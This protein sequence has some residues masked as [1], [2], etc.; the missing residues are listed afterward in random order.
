MKGAMSTAIF[1][2]FLMASS[3]SLAQTTIASTDRPPDGDYR[4]I[5]RQNG[6]EVGRSQIHILTHN[7]DVTVTEILV[8]GEIRV[9]S[10]AAYALSPLRLK[11][12]FAE[13]DTGGK[14]Q[15]VNGDVANGVV[16]LHSGSSELAKSAPNGTSVLVIADEFVASQILLPALLAQNSTTH[17]AAVSLEGG[18][19]LQGDSR[20]ASDGPDLAINLGTR[21]MLFTTAKPNFVVERIDIPAESVSVVL[22]R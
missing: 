8:A 4:Y 13:I 3:A 14:Q 20:I 17:F 22:E 18:A 11:T 1:A 7:D 16:T 10:R 12:Y 21:S 2:I 5:I 15:L 19:V 6:T 9:Q